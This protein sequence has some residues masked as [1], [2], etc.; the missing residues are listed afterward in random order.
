MVRSIIFSFGFWSYKWFGTSSS[1]RPPILTHMLFGEIDLP[2]L[3]P[4]LSNV[5]RKSLLILYLDWRVPASWT[6]LGLR[7]RNINR[8][9][10]LIDECKIIHA[11]KSYVKL[12]VGLRN[13][14]RT[15]RKDGNIKGCWITCTSHSFLLFSSFNTVWVTN[16]KGAG[17]TKDGTKN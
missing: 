8:T 9:N 13:W 10:Q 16:I 5:A 2:G 14:W 15:R 6:I 3:S 17:G 12:T 1:T 7:W 11:E 4:G